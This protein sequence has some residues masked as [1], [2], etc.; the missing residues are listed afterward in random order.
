M[1]IILDEALG[2]LLDESGGTI[3]DE[4]GAPPPENPLSRWN[5]NDAA[6]N[7]IF[8]HI[9][10]FAEQSGRFDSVNAHEPKNTPPNPSG[11]LFACWIQAIEPLGKASGLTS[12]SGVLVIS[13]RCYMGFRTEPFDA[14]DPKMVSASMEMMAR[15]A[16]DYDFGTVGGVRNVDIFGIS[17]HKL[18]SQAGYVESDRTVYRVMT[19][20]IPIIINDMFAFS[21]GA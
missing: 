9:L 1:A 10:A 13:A 5:F 3:L 2:A 6:V 18:Q 21:T 12:A 19:T 20:T 7:A 8:D 16:G 15:Y 14:I 17:G 4:L 11:M